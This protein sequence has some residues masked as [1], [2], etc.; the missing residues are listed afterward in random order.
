[1]GTGQLHQQ[2]TQSSHTSLFD[3]PCRVQCFHYLPKHPLPT[4]SPPFLSSYILFYLWSCLFAGRGGVSAFQ[5]VEVIYFTIRRKPLFSSFSS[6][7]SWSLWW[8]A[9]ICACLPSFKHST[10]SPLPQRTP[11]WLC[12]SAEVASLSLRAEELWIAA[13][14]RG[15][16]WPWPAN[17]FD[18]WDW[19]IDPNGLVP[20]SNYI[21]SQTST[22]LSTFLHLTSLPLHLDSIL[23][24]QLLFSSSHASAPCPRPSVKVIKSFLSP[25]HLHMLCLFSFSALTSVQVC[26]TVIHTKD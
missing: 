8:L 12:K 17:H 5:A 7:C 21:L 3:L 1:M 18:L 20:A 4:P 10:F 26:C 2:P 23:I 9:F 15:L 11:F 16:L 14:W 13:L 24:P 6:S 19:Q 25:L 22:I